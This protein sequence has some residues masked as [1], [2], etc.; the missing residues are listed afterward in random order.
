MVSV[1]TNK[2]LKFRAPIS[3]WILSVFLDNYQKWNEINQNMSALCAV[4]PALLTKDGRGRTCRSEIW[5]IL[6]DHRKLFWSSYSR[7]V[8]YM[9]AAEQI[10]SDR[11]SSKPINTPG[12]H[13]G[14]VPE[15]PAP[16]DMI[17]MRCDSPHCPHA[18]FSRPAPWPAPE[19]HIVWRATQT[20]RNGSK[21]RLWLM[22]APSLLHI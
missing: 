16:L 18:P 14:D 3:L 7:V 12:Q 8:F 13:P 11:A 2:S 10:Q 5:H 6:V 20:L 21:Q 17:H 9:S 19:R 1:N 15:I 4:A 22:A